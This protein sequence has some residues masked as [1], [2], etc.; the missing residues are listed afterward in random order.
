MKIFL[1]IWS[2]SASDIQGNLKDFQI[3]LFTVIL[4]MLF[5]QCFLSKTF[6]DFQSKLVFRNLFSLFLKIILIVSYET[7]CIFLWIV[8]CFPRYFYLFRCIFVWVFIIQ[9]NLI[10]WPEGLK[11]MLLG[12]L[13]PPISIKWTDQ[14]WAF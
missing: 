1:D 9:C 4:F 2:I 12:S 8:L 5:V 7:S 10:R 13:I 6:S 14:L 3:G 11:L